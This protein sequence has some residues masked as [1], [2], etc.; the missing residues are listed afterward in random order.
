MSRFVAMAR[1][2]DDGLWS[3]EPVSA[4]RPAQVATSAEPSDR[5]RWYAAGSMAGQKYSGRESRNFRQLLEKLVQSDRIVA[6]P[7]TRGVVDR[8]GHGGRDTAYAEFANSLGLHWRGHRVGL[9]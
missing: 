5:S 2:L 8:V 1:A 6:D 7:Y 4:P 9:V 3:C